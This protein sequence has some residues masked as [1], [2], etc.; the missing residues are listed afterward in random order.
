MIVL[1][2]VLAVALAG[3][4]GC[5][6]KEAP[7]EEPSPEPVA[8]EEAVEEPVQMTEVYYWPY[9]GLPA[10][11]GEVIK[12]R[13]LSIK[14]ENSPQSWPQTGLNDADVVYETRVEGGMSRFNCIFQSNIPKEV[15]PV[16]SAR[17]SDAWI[18]PQYNAML[19]YSGSNSEVSARLKKV[20]VQF[21][22]SGDLL[23]RVSFKSAPHNLYMHASKAYK[24]AKKKD[25]QL[26]F[27]DL[28][29]LY[30][31]TP[32]LSSSGAAI[33]ALVTAGAVAEEASADAADTA[34]ASDESASGTTVAAADPLPGYGGTP[35]KS[36]TIDYY[37]TEKW[38]WSV[39][40]QK[41][42]LYTSGNKHLDASTEK[43]IWTDNVVVMYAEYTQAQK[44]DPAGSPTYN[45]NLG[46]EGKAV[47]LRDGYAY[48]CTWKADEN[49]PPALYA[50]DGTQIPLKP[51][52]TWFEVPPTSGM[53]VTFE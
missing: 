1:A 38:K 49:T 6:K 23:Y 39:K 13:P 31:G 41:Y 52:K 8:T 27:D 3:M 7:K 10:P 4:A 5:K 48:E 14:I 37:S 24:A 26:D 32:G 25:I 11:D 43:Q 29:P 28:K 22:P 21:G 42:I 35:N 15:G 53:E 34:A 36:V 33:T 19:Y 17:L 2:V 9:T 20:G 45:T 18:V 46:G 47:L 30:Y 50:A 44:K 16:R 40:K 12:R 51:G